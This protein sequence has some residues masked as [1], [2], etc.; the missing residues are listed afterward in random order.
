MAIVGAISAEVTSMLGLNIPAGT[1][2]HLGDSNI[3]HMQQRH[4]DDYAKYGADLPSILAKPDYVG[5][6]PKDGS[7]EYVKDYVVNGE[8]VKVAVRISVSGRFFARSMYV[9]NHNRVKN[10]IQKGTLKH[11]TVSD[12]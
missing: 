5:L 4:P 1:P 2:I 10:F 9:L 7:I 3:A 11:L 6:N 12:E 8:Y